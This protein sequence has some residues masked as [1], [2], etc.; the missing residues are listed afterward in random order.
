MA[1]E[2]S[3]TPESEREEPAEPEVVEEVIPEE[4]VSVHSR[5]QATEIKPPSATRR[6]GYNLFSRDT[7]SGRFFRGLLRAIALL[8]ILAGGALLAGYLLF[9]QPLEDSMNQVSASA[10]ETAVDLQRSQK[11]LE[12]TQASLRRAQQSEDEAVDRLEIEQAR[13]QLLRAVASLRSAE[14][15]IQVGDQAAAEQSIT[16]AEQ[17]L[18]QSQER[19]EQIDPE[20]SSNLQALFT[21]VRNGMD[22][23]IEVASQDLTRLINELSR[24]ETDLDPTSE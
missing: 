16:E 5:P 2:P 9:Y 8:I 19:I 17:T 1:D 3:L 24:L 22:R 10:T 14:T 21:L 12:D 20:S 18:E 6:F 23:D 15:A 13:V 7:R 11:E 4:P